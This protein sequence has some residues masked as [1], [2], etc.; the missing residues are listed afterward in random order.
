MIALVFFK[1]EYFPDFRKKTG[2]EFPIFQDEGKKIAA[3]YNS[4]ICP[5]IWVLDGKGNV[6]FKNPKMP[7]MVPPDET[8]M[9]V[10]RAFEHPVAPAP[11]PKTAGK[12]NAP[13]T[14]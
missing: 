9:L 5:R 11:K 8:V 13:G 1:K 14:R 4:Y 6:V 7:D 3:K 10:R 12:P 2:A